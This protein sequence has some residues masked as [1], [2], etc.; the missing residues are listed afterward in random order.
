VLCALVAIALVL[1]GAVVFAGD[2]GVSDPTIAVKEFTPSGGQ[3]FKDQVKSSLDSLDTAVEAVI[4]IADADVAQADTNATTTATLYTPAKVG[5]LLI[6][7]AG[8]TNAV[9]VSKGVTTND[10]VR[11]AP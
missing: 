5:Q 9:W 10:W 6:G 4:D 2:S 8:S 3:V 11:V 7:A 1:G